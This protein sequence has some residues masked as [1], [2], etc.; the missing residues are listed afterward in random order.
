[1]ANV[2]VIISQHPGGEEVLLEQAGRDATTA[3]EDVGHSADAK[4]MMK[5]YRIGVYVK[6]GC[7]GG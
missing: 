7:W 5:E 3:F 2:R 6:V 1:M 4:A